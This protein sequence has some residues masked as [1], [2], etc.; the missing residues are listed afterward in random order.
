MSSFTLNN[1]AAWLA[2]GCFAGSF[3]LMLY[4]VYQHRQHQRQLRE[5]D[6]NEEE[7]GASEWWRDF[8][9]SKQSS[10]SGEFWKQR[11]EA[12]LQTSTMIVTKEDIWNN[13]NNNLPPATSNI[14]TL[15][16]SEKT[17]TSRIGNGKV[18]YQQHGAMS[19]PAALYHHHEGG[20]TD[21]ESRSHEE[22]SD[23]GLTSSY[24]Y[25]SSSVAPCQTLHTTEEAI[26]SK[27]DCFY[28]NPSEM[29]VQE[30]ES[31]PATP[32]K[33]E[34]A[35]IS[36]DA[37]SQ[38]AA[39]PQSATI[40]SSPSRNDTP[41]HHNHLQML[42][43]SQSQSIS[44]NVTLQLPLSAGLEDEEDIENGLLS[45]QQR[46]R[47]VPCICSIC[48]GSYKVGERV[49][50]STMCSHAFHTECLVQ[51]A[52]RT[53]QFD[54]SGGTNP[55]PSTRNAANDHQ[56]VLCPLCRRPYVHIPPPTHEGDVLHD[57]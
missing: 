13:N 8:H 34:D 27:P 53:L 5:L 25:S 35:L 45:P 23:G 28:G 22:S 56:F 38:S 52:Q 29:V 43:L 37:S 10:S 30:E 55:Q 31:S 7:H 44:D 14:S 20:D 19:P 39:T 57:C 41:D 50:W 46:Q 1:I 51:Y 42:C 15:L 36:N 21:E 2:V 12:T 47:Q 26:S 33:T 32:Q 18:S 9:H 6:D 49:S 3:L 11:L 40:T 16:S 17:T 54:A 24:S 48:L 4:A